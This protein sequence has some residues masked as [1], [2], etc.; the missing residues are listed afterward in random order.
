MTFT[1]LA[2]ERLNEIVTMFSKTELMP[3]VISKRFL[4]PIKLPCHNW[5]LGNYL[6][7]IS[8]KTE[9]ARGIKQWRE[10]GR[11]PK[12]GCHAV[13]ILV[14]MQQ[15]IEKEDTKTGEKETIFLTSFRCSPVFRF[16]DTEGAGIKHVTQE[17]PKP[18]L[19][20]V[21]EKWGVTVRYQVQQG[22]YGHFAPG[23]NEIVLGTD[24]IS[25]FFHELAHKADEKLNGKL[26]PGQ[27]AEQEATAELSACV[28]CKIY[29]YDIK[30]QSYNYISM[31]SGSH[32]PEAVGR[33][34]LKVLKRVDAILKTILETTQYNKVVV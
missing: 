11:H 31:Y 3:E 20:D 25:T 24:D 21:A 17:P 9:D 1:Q 30:N 4:S 12:K 18:P 16:E 22:E 15:Q 27:E 33:L 5:S 19:I 8:Q 32:K 6:L 34:C 26:K 23:R 10:V 28:L 13:Y 2:Q 7:M 29:G 14:P